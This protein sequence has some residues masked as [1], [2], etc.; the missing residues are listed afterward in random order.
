MQGPSISIPWHSGSAGYKVI[1]ASLR[2]RHSPAA[3]YSGPIMP[4]GKSSRSG[5][6]TSRPPVLFSAWH[7][8]CAAVSARRCGAGTCLCPC[9]DSGRARHGYH[10]VA[11]SHRLLTVGWMVAH[12]GGDGLVLL[13]TIR[14]CRITSAYQRLLSLGVRCCVP[15]STWT[16]PNRFSYPSAHS[17]LSSSDQRK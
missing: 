13:H 10:Q 7:G 11:R 15:N 1:R 4:G 8:L 16:I 17:K 2:S 12:T 14:F 9:R 5:I 3:G 6:W